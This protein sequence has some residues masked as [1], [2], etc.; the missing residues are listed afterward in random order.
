MKYLNI[1]YQYLKSNI[2]TIIFFTISYYFA[3]VHIN[4][5]LL[6]KGVTS[7]HAERGDVLISNIVN[8]TP[9]GKNTFSILFL[10]FGLYVFYTTTR[11]LIL[12]LKNNDFEWGSEKE[13]QRQKN[14][15]TEKVDVDYLIK[16]DKM[17]F[18]K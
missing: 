18:R 16:K 14:E 3:F 5:L 12:K 1:I 9:G 15:V 10:F 13:P 7:S 4:T 8:I 11:K 6:K 17:K 2:T